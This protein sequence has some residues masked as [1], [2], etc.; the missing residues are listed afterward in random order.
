LHAQILQLVRLRPRLTIINCCR[1]HGS[2]FAVHLSTTALATAYSMAPPTTTIV[3]FVLS[4]LWTCLVDT[5]FYQKNSLFDRFFTSLSLLEAI[6]KEASLT[7]A[8]GLLEVVQAAA[9][10]TIAYF[11]SLPTA[12]LTGFGVYAIVLEKRGQRSRLYIGSATSASQGLR[13]RMRDYEE[14]ERTPRFVGDAYAEGFEIA[15]KGLL[16]WTPLPGPVAVPVR[17]LLIVALE[18][19]LTYMFWAL[20]ATKGDYGM[21]HIC[22]WDRST[23]T[24]GG[25]CSHSSLY[26]GVQGDFDLSPEQ[27]EENAIHNELKRIVLKAQ[28][29]TNYHYKQMVVN[30]DDYIGKAGARVAKF[31]VTKPGQYLVTANARAEK[32]LDEKTYHCKTCDLSFTTQHSLND[33]VVSLKHSRKVTGAGAHYCV[34]CNITFHNKSNATRHN[35]QDGHKRK[36]AALANRSS[37]ALG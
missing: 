1:C 8:P 24:Y 11:K 19:V 30:Y 37:E 25:L 14:R 12:P 20:K 33:H 29:A 31:R 2:V 9:P 16:C 15:H 5:P 35:K 27:L 10:P 23:L 7:F 18:A 28:N 36:V 4:L 13:R 17:R 21:G 3:A 6:A 34:A 32:A 22:L 26:E